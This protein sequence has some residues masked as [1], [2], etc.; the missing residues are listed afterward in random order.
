MLPSFENDTLKVTA[1][2]TTNKYGAPNG[3]AVTVVTPTET[4]CFY[5][6]TL[7]QVENCVEWHIKNEA[8][9]AA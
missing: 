9:K 2:R 3:F 5:L 6:D 1:V 4:K 7:S 8:A